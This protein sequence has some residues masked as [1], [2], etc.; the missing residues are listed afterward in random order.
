MA[1]K[2]SEI[3][4]GTEKEFLDIF[5]QLCYS[6][7]SWQVWADVISAIACSISNVIDRSQEHYK[8]MEEEYAGCIERLGSVEAPTKIL[9][10][11]VMALENNPEQDFLGKM[12]VDLKMFNHWKGQ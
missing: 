12:Y 8:K 2:S 7:S 10:T 4:Q 1:K 11:I 3:I 6:R 9:G 5:K